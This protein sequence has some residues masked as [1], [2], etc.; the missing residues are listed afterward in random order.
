MAKN[1]QKLVKMNKNMG[2]AYDIL[3]VF[4]DLD[5]LPLFLLI[6]EKKIINVNSKYTK[7]VNICKKKY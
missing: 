4:I 2:V 1:E 5:T 6:I 7:S 3:C